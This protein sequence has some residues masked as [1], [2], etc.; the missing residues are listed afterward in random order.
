VTELLEASLR[1]P[2]VIFTIGLGIALVYWV[3][4]L[5]GALD[6]DLFGGG[7]DAAGATKGGMEALKGLKGIGG[8]VHGGGADGHAHADG[9][10]GGIWDWLGVASVPITI[11]FSVIMLLGWVLSLLG[12]SYA[13]RSI[14]D[15][16]GWLP[17]LM[18]IAVLIVAIVVGG[19]LVKPLGSVFEIQAGKSNQDYVGHVCTI[20]TGKVDD[21][22]GQATLEDG[23]TVLVIP[24]RC[25]KPD[26]LARGHKALI[27]DFDRSRDA[28]L[29][30]PTTDLMARPGEE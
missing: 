26:A 1:F 5:L 7:A 20:T 3:F 18:L 25:D 6:I 16:A 2:T 24:V 28:Y 14:G 30:E 17:A 13:S 15:L 9:D 27:I 23:G 29:V 19:R 22:F 11:S 21:G 10:G 8:D 12:M 4:V